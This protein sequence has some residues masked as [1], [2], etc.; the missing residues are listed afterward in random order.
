MALLLYGFPPGVGATG[1]A[2]LLNVP[3]SLSALLEALS[4]AGYELGEAGKAGQV[5]GE[6]LITALKMQEE[7][8]AIMEG[9]AGIERRSGEGLPK[10]HIWLLKSALYAHAS[11]V[12]TLSSHQRT[13]CPSDSLLHKTPTC[14]G[15]MPPPPPFGHT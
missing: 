4:D 9:P 1:T 10:F 15:L 6:A 2:A 8:R 13:L 11:L 5:D 3:K 7:Q 12:G 14:S